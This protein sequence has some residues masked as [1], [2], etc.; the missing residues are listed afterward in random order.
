MMLVRFEFPNITYAE[1]TGLY[2]DYTPYTEA[3]IKNAITKGI[4]PNRGELEI[5][6]LR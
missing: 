5:W 6:M 2:E 4:E 3:T 1:L